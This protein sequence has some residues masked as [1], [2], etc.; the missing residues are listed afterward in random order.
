MDILLT[1][2][3][4]FLGRTIQS[5]L[6]GFRIISLGRSEE[7]KI[8]ADITKEIIDL[9]AVDMVIHAAGKA[10]SIPTTNLEEQVFFDVNYIGTQNLLKGFEVNLP[11]FFVYISTVSVYGRGTGSLL[12]EDTLLSATDAY[13]QSKILAEQVVRQWCAHNNVVCTILR[14]PLIAGFNPPGNLKAMI[15]GI[16]KGY[17]FNI[18]GNKAKKSIV[19][20]R[21][22]AR[23]IPKAAQIGGVYNLTDGYHPSLNELSAIIARQLQRKNPKSIPLI[24]ARFIAYLGTNLSSKIP[25]TIDKL[26]KMTSNLTF[27]DEKAREQLDWAPSPVLEQFKILEP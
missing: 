9:P 3:S 11:R 8:V 19:L 23:I 21:D 17:Y 24:V 27:S 20:A 2:A 22:V 16:K 1:G 5:E 13:G 14:L 25:L 26:N 15:S 18:S 6:C 12:T 7:N 4:G 10:H